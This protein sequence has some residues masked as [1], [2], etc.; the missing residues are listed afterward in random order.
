M[1]RIL[2]V[3]DDHSISEMVN[4]AVFAFGAAGTSLVPI[5]FGMRKHSVPQP[6]YH[7]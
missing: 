3:E 7:P 4:M 2:L 6:S 1:Q 5:F